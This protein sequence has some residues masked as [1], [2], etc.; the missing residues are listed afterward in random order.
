MSEYKTTIGLTPENKVVMDQIMGHFNEQMDAARFAM[1]LA[2]KSGEEPGEAE[3]ADTVWNV[4]SFDSNGE[5]RDLIQAMF[6]EN[7]SPYRSAEYF[8]NKGLQHVDDHLEEN[9]NLDVVQLI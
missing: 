1:A 3:N 4:G 9:K 5:I 2:I 7:D 8:I 6:P